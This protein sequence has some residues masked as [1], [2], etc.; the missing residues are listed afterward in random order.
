MRLLC[1]CLIGLLLPACALLN[2]LPNGLTEPRRTVVSTAIAQIGMPYRYGGASLRG[3]D[4]PG[5]AYYAY[6]QAGVSIPRYT[7]NQRRIGEQVSFAQARP[8]DLLFYMVQTRLDGPPS[9]HVGIYIGNGQ[10]VHCTARLGE[11]RVVEVNTEFWRSRFLTAVSIL[12]TGTAA[13]DSTD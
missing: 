7:D 12:P 2:P 9:P 4:P 10:M 13:L 6:R 11:V 1:T 5:L 3:F 8:G